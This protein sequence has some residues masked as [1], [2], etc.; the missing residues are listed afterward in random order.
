[1]GVEV[2]GST[3]GV[4]PNRLDHHPHIGE[5]SMTKLEKEIRERHHDF[6]ATYDR[7]P[8]FLYLGVIAY[9]ALCEVV[10]ADKAILEK[11]VHEFPYMGMKIMVVANDDTHVNCA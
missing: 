4:M 8:E 3:S 6:I 5:V 9:R 2:A 7:A 10:K 11:P 1:M